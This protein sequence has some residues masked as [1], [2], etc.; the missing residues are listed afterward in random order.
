MGQQL[1]ED[2]VQERFDYRRAWRTDML[3][4]GFG[5]AAILYAGR[6]GG[7]A[8]AAEQAKLQMFFE[9]VVQ[10]DAPIGRRFDQVNSAAR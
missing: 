5:D 9:A 3:T 4:R 10:L 6:T 1:S 8:G 7:L 2:K